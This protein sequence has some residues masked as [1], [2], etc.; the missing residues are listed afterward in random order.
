[1]KD[2]FLKGLIFIGKTV[3]YLF[4]L[5]IL[6][7][8]I[9]KYANP[10][11]TPIMILRLIEHANVGIHKDWVDYDEVAP[12]VYRSILAAEDARFASHNGVDW[13]A[14]KTARRYNEIHAGKRKH[15]ASTI[16]MQTA[17]NTFLT[18][19]RTYLRKGLEMYFTYMIEWI[20][21]KQRILEVYV[22]IV[23]WGDG[24]Y[25]IEEAAQFYFHKPASKLTSTQAARL[26]A[27]LPNPRRWDPSKPTNYI[28]KRTSSIK[29][30]A[31]G[32]SLR[33][34]ENSK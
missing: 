1:M 6:L 8:C 31:R 34:I 12:V 24:I 16:T 11:V 13:K 2:F 10:P 17:K 4:L 14:V 9:Y 21:G 29:A 28:R 19:H 5:S 7:V 20:W 3:G 18:H 27:V 15:G 25:G 26:A 30:R 22:N 32:I 23:E 33:A